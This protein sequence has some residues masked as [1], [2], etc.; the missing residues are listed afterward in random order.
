MASNRLAA[1][2]ITP[3]AAYRAIG[4]RSVGD[5]PPTIVLDNAHLYK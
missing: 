3:A 5:L 1:S 2:S 4:A